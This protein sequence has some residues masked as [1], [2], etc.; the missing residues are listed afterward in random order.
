M[1]TKIYDKYINGD[2]LT[3]G[4]VLEGMHSFKRAANALVGL[5]GAFKLACDECNRVYVNLHSFAVHRGIYKRE[6]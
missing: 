4:E 2:S 3:D 1:K 6:L 5:G